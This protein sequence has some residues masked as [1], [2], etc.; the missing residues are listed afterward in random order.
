V[1][2]ANPA[3]FGSLQ[4]NRYAYWRVALVDGFAKRPVTGVGA[5][6]FAA[7]WLRY[8]KITERVKV[9]HSLYVETLAELG[10]VGFGFLLIWFGGIAA[11]ARRAYNAAPMVAAGPIA[12]IVVFATHA[13]VDWDWEMPAV[14]LVALALAGCLV[15]IGDAA[16]A[17]EPPATPAALAHPRSPVPAAP[18]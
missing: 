11:S 8:R 12:A 16:D 2:G 6:G 4:T 7:I 10:L 1:T 15:G 14:T 3:R 18:V 13:A 9:A 17:A 5:G